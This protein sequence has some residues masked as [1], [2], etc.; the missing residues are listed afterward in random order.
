MNR[1]REREKKT[2][3]RETCPDD[4]ID[5]TLQLMYLIKLILYYVLRKKRFQLKRRAGNY[6]QQEQEKRKKS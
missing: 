3:G 6:M 4:C 5:L 1:E 2:K